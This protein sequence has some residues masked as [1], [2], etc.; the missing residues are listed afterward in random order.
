MRIK[1]FD[2]SRAQENIDFDKIEKSGAK[3]VIIRAGIRTDEDTYFRRYLNECTNRKIPYGLFWYF[4]ATS[5]EAF[6]KELA[7][8]VKIVKGLKPEY[9]VFFD[10]EE[11]R[12]IDNLTSKERTD[13]ALEFC[14]RLNK[15]GLP[16]GVYA[17]PAW[18]ESYYQKERIVGKRDIWL[19]SFRR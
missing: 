4:E 16:S 17:N 5:D 19:C 10:M 14:D 1:G 3:F 9:P 13:M 2:I 12:Q 11:Q 6:D 18:L 15:A 7:A 8:C